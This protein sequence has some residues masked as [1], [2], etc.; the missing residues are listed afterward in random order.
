M[1]ALTQNINTILAHK[2]S[3]VALHM[4]NVATWIPTTQWINSPFLSLGKV[5]FGGFFGGIVVDW[6]TDLMSL[7]PNEKYVNM[8]VLGL[9]GLGCAKNIYN[10][11][12][13][14]L[15]IKDSNS[16]K[17]MIST[18]TNILLNRHPNISAL[19]LNSTGYNS[20]YNESV[21]TITISDRSHLQDF[22]FRIFDVDEAKGVIETLGQLRWDGLFFHGTSQG[23]FLVKLD[24]SL[25]SDDT[26]I[27]FNIANLPASYIDGCIRKV[28]LFN[29]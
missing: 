26:V 29:N 17:D 23:Y 14:T 16:N 6:G 11:S 25:L 22:L 19:N 27:S 9:A 3:H 28:S 12:T 15:T 13:K 10:L 18:A 7:K 24:D 4:L 8:A 5:A 21:Q 20:F 1:S 2:S